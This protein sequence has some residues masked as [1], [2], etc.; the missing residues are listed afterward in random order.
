MGSVAIQD[1]GISVLDLTGV[2]HDDD[3]SQESFSFSWWIVLGISANISS[4]D[5]LDGKT[6][7]VESDVVS[8]NSFWDGFVMHF[9]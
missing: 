2:V 3:L 4:F 5:I 9:D 1:W 7:N 6:F 8:G